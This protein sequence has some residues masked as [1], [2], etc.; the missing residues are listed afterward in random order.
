MCHPTS[1]DAYI[2]NETGPNYLF[3]NSLQIQ[4]NHMYILT[5]TSVCFTDPRAFRATQSE[6]WQSSNSLFLVT[7]LLKFYN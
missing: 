4:L 2:D 7:S 3:W 5:G 1:H 6:V